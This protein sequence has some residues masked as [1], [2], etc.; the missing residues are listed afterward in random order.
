MKP[1][2]FRHTTQGAAALHTPHSTP[3]T[4]TTNPTRQHANTNTAPPE[5]L[6]LEQ[7]LLRHLPP[8]PEVEPARDGERERRDADA[9]RDDGVEMLRR[10]VGQPAVEVH[11]EERR[12]DRRRHDRDVDH[13]QPQVDHYD[14]VAARVELHVPDLAARFVDV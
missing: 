14:V 8:V 6:L 7:L 1:P 3:P 9:Q 5:H 12:Q 11:A 2:S 10:L 4:K 13:R